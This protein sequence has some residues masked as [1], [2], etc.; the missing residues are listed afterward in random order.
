[1]SRRPKSIQG[2][3]VAMFGAL[4]AASA[5]ATS[6]NNATIGEPGTSCQSPRTY[7]LERAWGP[8]LAPKCLGCHSVGGQA[9][10]NNPPARFTL[11]PAS[12]PDFADSNI[13][14]VR[15][16]VQQSIQVNGR[17]VPLILAKPLGLVPHGGMQVVREGTPE[18]AALQGLV[19][20][21]GSSEATNNCPDYGSLA[22]PSGIALMDWRTTLRKAAL[23]F[24]GRLPTDAEYAEVQTN[25]QR[26]FET[27]MQAIFDENGFYERWRTAFND[28]MLTDTYITTSGCD[29]RALNLISGDDFPNRGTYGGGGACCDGNNPDYNTA[30]CQ[31]RRDFMLRANNAIAQEPV[32]L[33]EYIVRQNRSFGEILTADYTL[34][35]AQSAFVYGVSEQVNFSD[36]YAQGSD[37]R[38]A[39]LTYRR[40]YNAMR[41]E[42]PLP[43]PHAGV[44]SMPTFLSRYPTTQTNRNRHR[45]R[46]VQAYFLATDILKVGERPIDSTAAEALIMTPTMNYGPCR[47]CH[48]INDPIAGAFR[49][50][51]PNGTNWRWDPNDAWYTDMAPPGFAG[52]AMP[53]TNYR[54]ALQWIAPRIVQDERFA[55][56]V[57]R[58][59]YKSVSNR[60]PLAHP[61]DL[62]DPLYA[63]RSAAWS[64]QDRIF[65]GIARR[66]VAS[67][68]NFK[69]A[70]LELLES[71]I[72]RA[73]AAVM[74]TGENQREAA[75]VAHSGIGTAMLATP[76]QLDRR[77]RAIAG[78]PWMRDLNPMRLAQPDGRDNWNHWLRQEFYLPYGG[79][80]SDTIV[81][82]VADPSGII[83]GI[84]QRMATEVACRGT[85][86]DFTLPQAERRFFRNVQLDTVPEAG[87]NAVPGNQQI[88]KQNIAALHSLILGEQLSADDPEVERTFQLFLDT[89]RET[90][91]SGM[92]GMPN[93]NLRYECQ[94]RQ[95]PLSGAE[96][97]EAQR[98]TEDRN[99]TIR[100]WMAVMTYLFS[101]YKFL[102]Q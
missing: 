98:I 65:R 10:L 32:N 39:R 4:V 42:S 83:V 43:Y 21:L 49:G 18:H 51:F 54:N 50:F 66:F 11:L 36:P 27:V 29:Q 56:S 67:N 62:Q 44:L 86:W 41:S 99:G 100:A 33:F 77:V 55:M 61:T 59:I 40:V 30:M 68:M 87:G 96:L 19:E 14:S 17:Q 64:E 28:M 81:R 5:S 89:W 52:E 16:M 6:C 35:N 93:N 8:V 46:I 37:L 22:A 53:G 94:G 26:G 23:D 47:T 101:D 9:A 20:R 45:A 24:V 102:Y 73:E 70:V 7:F 85:A 74:P 63:Q 58:F 1:M 76:E 75:L 95:N 92:G 82:R 25:G 91:T 79:I 60:E 69:T 57:V 78:F 97:P 2:R 72:Y 31:Q 34:V 38:P 15:A 90:R 48:A 13:A 3:A 71:P 84:A 12:Y 88:I 80:N